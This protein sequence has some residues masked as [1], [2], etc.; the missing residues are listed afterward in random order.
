[1]TLD[2]DQVWGSELAWEPWEQ[3]EV[4]EAEDEEAD[5]AIG[6]EDKCIV[7]EGN[8][9]EGSLGAVAEEVHSK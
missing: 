5:I 7:E 1:M 4:L 2:L 6:V 8:T 9:E 3:E